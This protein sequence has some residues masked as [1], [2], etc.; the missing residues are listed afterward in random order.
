MATDP[1]PPPD[2]AE[3]AGR[4]RTRRLDRTA[5]RVGIGVSV[6]VHI[7][8]VLAYPGLLDRMPEM[9]MSP[10]SDPDDPELVGIEI[11]TFQEVPDDPEPTEVTTPPEIVVDLP[12]PME[13]EA[14]L[15]VPIPAPPEIPRPGTG[16]QAQ[17]DDPD[18]RT[19]WERLQPQMGD[20]RLWAPLSRDYADLTDEERAELLLRAMIRDWNDSVAVAVALSGEATDWTF[21]DEQGRRWGLSPG[22][23]HLGDFS[24]PLPV[25][26]Q[27]PQARRNDMMVRDWEVRDILRGSATAEVRQSWAERAREIRERLDAERARAQSGSG[28]GSGGSG[29]GGG[30]GSGGGS[31]GPGPGGGG[32]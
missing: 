11:V 9:R 5:I 21:T 31:G 27:M 6:L 32:N 3:S 7:L 17:A 24:I 25:S 28:S 19:A 13:E 10:P 12:D 22:R 14:P 1:S 2:A 26:F 15:A 8:L 20:P 30:G 16:A 4:S 23:L 18:P 29:G